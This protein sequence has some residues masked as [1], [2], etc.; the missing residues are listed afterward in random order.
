LAGARIFVLPGSREKFSQA[1]VTR[2]D[3]KVCYDTEYVRA[4]TV[5]LFAEESTYAVN[6]K[7]QNVLRHC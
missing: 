1:E 7:L 4:I 2:L 3:Y 5:V 6:W